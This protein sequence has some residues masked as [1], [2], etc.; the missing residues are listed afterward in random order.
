MLMELLFVSIEQFF[1]EERCFKG[2]TNLCVSTVNGPTHLRSIQ[3]EDR[4]NNIC[5]KLNDTLI[6]EDKKEAREKE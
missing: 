2:E 3:V 1:A 5:S 6:E 4:F